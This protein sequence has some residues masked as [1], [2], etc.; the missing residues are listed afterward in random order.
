MNEKDSEEMGVGSSELQPNEEPSQ[1][2][3]QNS[4][5]RAKEV[6]ETAAQVK[7]KP[8]HNYEVLLRDADS[9]VDRSSRD[10]LYDQ[11]CS[12]LLLNQ[13]RK[14]YWVDKNS[15]NC[16]F[17]YARNLTI[18]WIEDKRYWQW[19]SIQETRDE[20]IDV[21]ELLNVCWLEVHGK[22]QTANLS[23]GTLYELA[24]VVKLKDPAYGWE[25]P[26]NVR[27]T[28]P[29]GNKQEHKENLMKK[30]RGDW[31]EIPVGEFVPSPENTGEIEF[32]IYEYEGGEWKRGLVIK[33]ITIRPKY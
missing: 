32:S 10:K 20:V 1:T 12:G 21:A 31:I 5:T 9:P 30:P 24:F 13:K 4:D 27:L 22:F 15:N 14:K 29:D 11:L 28:L 7:V 33:G 23:P 8:P 2:E 26:V 18:S 19:R 17:L 6:N 16:F 25:V 3:T